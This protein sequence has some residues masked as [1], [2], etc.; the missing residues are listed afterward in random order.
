MDF[1]IAVIKKLTKVTSGGKVDFVSYFDSAYQHGFGGVVR[2]T[3]SGQ[4][5]VSSVRK[6]KATNAGE[7]LTFS[8]LVSVRPSPCS[9][10]Y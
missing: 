5:H 2:G 4:S 10:I 9:D 1:L 3:F 7:E 8:F 6:Q